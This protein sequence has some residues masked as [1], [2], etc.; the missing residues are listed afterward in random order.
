M[1]A[2]PWCYDVKGLSIASNASSH[3]LLCLHVREGN[4]RQLKRVI[5]YCSCHILQAVGSAQH[6]YYLINCH[7]PR[8]CVLSLLFRLPEGSLCRSYALRVHPCISFPKPYCGL[9]HWL[10]GFRYIIWN[11]L[12]ID[13]DQALQVCHPGRRLV[14]CASAGRKP[15]TIV[16]AAVLN[17]KWLIG[18]HILF[19]SA[20]RMPQRGSV[21]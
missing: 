20:F 6:Y 21:L 18:S 17:S 10:G 7:R 13:L 11:G 8:T 2:L 3:P 19:P 4:K 14:R 9:H 1:A 16:D 12:T 5:P 15:R